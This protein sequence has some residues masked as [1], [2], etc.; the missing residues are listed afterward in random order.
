M[1][2]FTGIDMANAHETATMSIGEKITE[3]ISIQTAFTIQI[4]GLKIPV[5]ETV[6]WTWIIMVVLVLASFLITRKLKEVPAAPQ[7]LAETV[8]EF[9]DGFVGG[10]MGPAGKAYAPFLGTIGLYLAVANLLPMLTP[11]GGFGHE[12]VFEIKPIMRDINITGALAL[13]V[14]VVVL[15]SSIAKRGPLGW[16]RSLV[17]PVAFM[18]P[19]NILEYAIRPVSLALRL[20]GNILGAFIIMR[21]IEA[22]MP[23]GV[24]VLAGLYFDLFDG[25]LQTVVFVYL[26]TIFIAEAI[27]MEA[28]HE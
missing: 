1:T 7:L 14:I 24:P 25:V 18:L 11:V 4:G 19:F 2:S 3:A 28:L 26:S 20:F 22:L 23:V 6:V 21:L 12:P 5:S 9:F 16:L 15:G 27:H 13:M 17:K 10:I 8:I